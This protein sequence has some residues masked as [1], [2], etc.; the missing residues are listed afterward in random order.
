MHFSSLEKKK[1]TFVLH[2]LSLKLYTQERQ[3]LKLPACR[4][5]TD[6]IFC[7]QKSVSPAASFLDDWHPY[8]VNKPAK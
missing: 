3:I 4:K 6:K 2:Q 5:V 1:A 7:V 8:A